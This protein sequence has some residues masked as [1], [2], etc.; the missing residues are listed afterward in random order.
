MLLLRFFIVLFCISCKV[1]A[2]SPPVYDAHVN[3]YKMINTDN[4]KSHLLSHMTLIHTY[5]LSFLETKYK[6]YFCIGLNN[7]N[8]NINNV[9]NLSNMGN[10][11]LNKMP[12]LHNST[13]VPYVNLYKL[14][15][16]TLNNDSMPVNVSGVVFMPQGKHIKGVILYFHSTI[17]SKKD[18]YSDE[19]GGLFDTVIAALFAADGYIV[20]APDYIGY[21]DSISLIHP[22][23]LYPQ[24]NALDGAYMLSV[25]YRCLPDLNVEHKGPIPLFVTGYSEGSAYVLWFSRLYQEQKSFRKIIDHNYKIKLIVPIDGAY[26]I[27][28]V[29][30][31]YLYSNNTIFNKS[32]YQLSSVF[33]AGIFKAP[34]SALALMSYA[35]Y[36]LHGDYEKVFNPDFFFMKCSMLA[37]CTVDGEHYSLYS[38]ILNTHFG[39][40]GLAAE[41]M[42][43][44]KINSAALFVCNNHVCYSPLTNNV[45]ALVQTKLLTS[46]AFLQSLHKADVYYWHSVLPT[47]LISLKRDSIVSPVN[48]EYA[49]K[50]M[51][52]ANSKNLKVV[53]LDNKLISNRL[54]K[55]LS[56]VEVDH[57][58]GFTFLFLIAR[59]LFD[60]S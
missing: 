30:Y 25:F 24:V 58:T 23:V 42:F 10:F 38:L 45:A 59:H 27:S 46:A 7:C 16:T 8:K 50:G 47:V 41:K 53:Y 52:S 54:I 48:T 44:D 22:Y 18:A 13:N 60:N 34:L 37:N 21:G 32:D 11:D 57:T 43:L 9:K 12:I 4:F 35:Y 14:A 20:V 5:S 55:W 28:G 15:Y 51:M 2:Y 40:H 31:N 17:F 19:Y 49:Y 1:F 33:T 3:H 39:V 36:D 6:K 29:I 26:D 56:P